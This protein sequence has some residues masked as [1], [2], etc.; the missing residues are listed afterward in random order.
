MS[1]LDRLERAAKDCDE[2]V[3]NSLPR[4][5]RSRESDLRDLLLDAAKHI[6]L[7]SA[8]PPSK[9]AHRFDEAAKHPFP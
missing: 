4:N 3:A 5:Y 8:T 1:I 2:R 6:R 7:L 9:T